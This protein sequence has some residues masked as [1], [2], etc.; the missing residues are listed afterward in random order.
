MIHTVITAAAPSR[1][2]CHAA[3]TRCVE[4]G[5]VLDLVTGSPVIAHTMAVGSATP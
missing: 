3:S 2:A 5:Q 4:A 1:S